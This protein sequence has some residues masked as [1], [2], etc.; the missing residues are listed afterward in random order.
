[1]AACL[2]P[3]ATMILPASQRLTAVRKD[4]AAKKN[5][6]YIIIDRWGEWVILGQSLPRICD[7]MNR[8]IVGDAESDRV[9]VTR[10]FENMNRRPDTNVRSP[11]YKNRYKVHAVTLDE[12]K[13][14]F[15]SFRNDFPNAAIVAGRPYR[16]QI[17]S[18]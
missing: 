8:N 12:A 4:Y 10:L 1:M 16:Y 2:M 14:A 15:E 18:M 11:W 13:S 9:N 5:V 17:T 3:H 7:Y 6:A